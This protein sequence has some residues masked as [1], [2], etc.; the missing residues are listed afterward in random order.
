MDTADVAAQIGV[1]PR[2]V[3][4]WRRARFLEAR[5]VGEGRYEYDPVEVR[6]GRVVDQ[7]CR[8]SAPA[9]FVLDAAQLARGLPHDVEGLLVVQGDGMVRLAADLDVLDRAAWV[10][11]V[12]AVRELA[13]A[14]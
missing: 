10:V 8:L 9:S 2:L 13:T 3:D 4:V 14:A 5:R 6:V 11:T 7:L 12:D 1:T